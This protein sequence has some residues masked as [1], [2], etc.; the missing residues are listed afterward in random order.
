MSKE[1]KFQA[2][3]IKELKERF[4]GCM[5]LKNDA[6]YLQGI[7]DLLVLFG[8]RWAMLECK[9]SA[10]SHRQPNQEYYVDKFNGMSYASFV[11]PENKEQ[12]L[13]ELQQTFKLGRKARASKR[14]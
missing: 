10:D 12:V 14:E 4:E 5:V 11:Y 7:C 9:A 1:S 2:K 6:N 3:L 8:E 13:D